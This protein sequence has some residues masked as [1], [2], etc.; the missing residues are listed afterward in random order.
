MVP[1]WGRCTPILVCCSGDWD[2]HWGYDLDFAPW[3]FGF[4]RERG[5]A[6]KSEPRN[7]V[8]MSLEDSCETHEW[9]LNGWL[10]SG[11]VEYAGTPQM[12]Y[13]LVEC[14]GGYESCELHTGLGFC[15]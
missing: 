5:R 11:Q 13:I 2:V 10:D 12:R 1:F 15:K 4:A 6:S 7:M 8:V 14:Q 9:H 3:P